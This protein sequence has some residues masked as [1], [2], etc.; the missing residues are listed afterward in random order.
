MALL[1]AGVSVLHAEPA[2]VQVKEAPV[3]AKPSAT[4]KFLGRLPLGTALSVV[5]R[6]SG[7]ARVEGPT[8]SGWLR[9]QTFTTKA[10]GLKA[11]GAAGGVTST[12]VSLA[13]RAFTPE[14]EAEYER[15]NP[16]LNYQV[17]DAMEAS[18]VSDK[19]LDDFVRAGDL[20]PDGGRR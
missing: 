4:S 11:G 10:L 14:V 20:S 19:D 7:W 18:G 1:A 17:L 3:Y 15:R 9:E 2:T 12:E 6:K 16:G 5:D 13:G 8:L